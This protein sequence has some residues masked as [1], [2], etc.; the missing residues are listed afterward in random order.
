M[1]KKP[2]QKCKT[3]GFARAVT[4]SEFGRWFVTHD[5]L[6]EIRRASTKP[7]RGNRL[8]TPTRNGATPCACATKIK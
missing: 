6:A 2:D 3:G 8:S 1:R 5:D 7:G 4:R